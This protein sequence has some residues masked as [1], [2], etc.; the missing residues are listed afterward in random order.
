[1]R[2]TGIKNVPDN[3][4][5]IYTCFDCWKKEKLKILSFAE[6]GQKKKKR[7]GQRI[8]SIS[9]VQLGATHVP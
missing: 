4:K 3:S 6:M 1:M 2:D 8:I 9:S 5:Q 7:N